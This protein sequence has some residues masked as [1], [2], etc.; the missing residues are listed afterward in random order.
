MPTSGGGFGSSAARTPSFRH[1]PTLKS[2]G[3]PHEAL[4][5]TPCVIGE[6]AQRSTRGRVFGPF[7]RLHR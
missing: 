1:A 3:Q 5:F 4:T 6:F 7:R 2:D